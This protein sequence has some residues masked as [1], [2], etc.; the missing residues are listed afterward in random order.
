MASGN[1]SD[2]QLRRTRE[3]LVDGM[4]PRAQWSRPDRAT[5]FSKDKEGR[6]LEE[7][8]LATQAALDEY[9]DG[10]KEADIIK[11]RVLAK[12]KRGQLYRLLTR[13]LTLNV[14]TGT[15]N[16][17]WVCVPG[18][19]AK[20]PPDDPAESPY[21]KELRKFFD[22]HPTLEAELSA[23]CAIEEENK[24]KT[25]IPVNHLTPRKVHDHF[26]KLCRDRGL[27]EASPREWP[28]VRSNLDKETRKPGMV[29]STTVGAEAI[30]RWW[31][32]K[33]YLRPAEA[34]RRVMPPDIAALFARD[35][36]RL[37]EYRPLRPRTLALF[38]RWELDESMLNA[39]WTVML[40]MMNNKFQEVHTSRLWGLQI[41]EC[42]CTLRLAS[43]VSR[44]QRYRSSDVLRLLHRALFPPPRPELTLEHD[45][46]RYHEGAAYGLE[47]SLFQGSVC[48][49]LCLDSDS[50]HLSEDT[51]ACIEDVLRCAIVHGRI[52]VPEKHA[53]IE[54]LFT[55]WSTAMS[56]L[57]SATGSSIDDPARQHDAQD[58]AV[59]F[60]ITWSLAEEILDVL[61]RN[62]NVTPMVCLGGVSPLHAAQDL[63][64]QGR[65]FRS[66]FGQFTRPSLFRFL[67]RNPG[68]RPPVL[69]HLRNGHPLSPLVVRHGDG[70]YTSF[71]LNKDR[72]L[73]HHPNRNVDIYVQED[74]RFAFVVP[75]AFPERVYA[76]ALAGKHA[77]VPHT[78]E[79][80]LLTNRFA[81]MATA[82]H[83]ASTSNVM[84][85]VVGAL[86]S[87]R[88]NDKAYQH[89]IGGLLSFM[90]RAGNGNLTY[91]DLSE[92][93]RERL[94]HEA[95]E[96]MRGE[97]FDAD[98]DDG[99]GPGPGGPP[100][101]PS[102]PTPHAPG[103]TADEFNI[104][105]RQRYR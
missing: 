9:I 102:P 24:K 81:K 22:K 5:F 100:P 28:Y 8:Y 62:Q 90:G 57:P 72:D 18:W 43:A 83:R 44:F 96:I 34:A 67:P 92:E 55:A 47:P 41:A 95:K 58:A 84:A 46:Y 45:E 10:K 82:Q 35:H 70:L 89:F 2:I 88:T 29:D 103:T 68:S 93:D 56:M 99:R 48:K 80:R 49:T 13:A 20:V 86:A 21:G 12:L 1:P 53:F 79:M 36:E 98:A 17:Y 75:A 61:S 104:I 94:M 101:M 85:G 31:K 64:R 76:V 91:I 27:H 42:S 59:R 14:R 69:G 50:T 105:N 51:R 33:C 39:H 32:K 40:P 37:K 15:A 66:G 11:S 71:A 30:R 6:A 3:E 87:K 4:L 52:G 7:Q 38:E 63:W 60:R 19:S 97:G 25:D 16:G 74:A 73:Y 26:L 23:F 65:V 54:Q 77:A 78:V